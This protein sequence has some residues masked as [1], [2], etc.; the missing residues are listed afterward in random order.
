MALVIATLLVGCSQQDADHGI[1][2]REVDA[3][4]DGVQL[5]VQ[6]E[7]EV[8]LSRNAHVALRHGVP[9]TLR[10]R[11]ELRAAGS[12]HLIAEASEHWEIRY[13]PLSQHYQLSGPGETRN[14]PRLRHVL[15]A[16]ATVDAVLPSGTLE[17][18]DYVLRTRFWLDRSN[19]PAP[20]QLPAVLSAEWRHDSDW[21]SWPLRIDA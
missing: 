11:F 3:H 14:F 7:Q 21:S 16:L 13:L 9:L 20:M 19:L 15:S 6:V 17:S 18:G 2:I 10:V 5:D 12:R 4:P 1:L 8:R